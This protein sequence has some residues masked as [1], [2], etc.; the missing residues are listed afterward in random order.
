[1]TAGTSFTVAGMPAALATELATQ[2]DDDITPGN[3]IGLGMPPAVAVEVETQFD[4]ST[5]GDAQAFIGLGV[6]ALL[7]VAI[8]T[9]I[10][11]L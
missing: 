5:T 10:D 9:A 4:N 1:M 7:A 11:A 8:E 2:L 3:L 6:P